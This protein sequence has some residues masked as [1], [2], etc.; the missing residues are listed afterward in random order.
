MKTVFKISVVTIVLG[1]MMLADIPQ[2]PLQLVPDAEAI[3]GVR[4]RAF[5]QGCHSGCCLPE[6]FWQEQG[7]TIRQRPSSSPPPRS[8]NPQRPS[9]S[10]PPRSSNP[11]R[12]N[13]RPQVRRH[14]RLPPLR[15]ENRYP[16]E[17]L[18]TRFQ[19]GAHR[20]R[21][22]VWNTTIAVVTSIVR[23]FRGISWFM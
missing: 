2:L 11:Q 20:P 4:R 23:C 10:P 8:S 22:V 12:P 18:C 3:F 19:E 13:S 21:S 16:S 17:P 14:P 6:G 7:P 5:P 9:S 1:L 15:R